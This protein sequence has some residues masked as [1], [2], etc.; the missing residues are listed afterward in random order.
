M[1]IGGVLV[2]RDDGVLAAAARRHARHDR[3]NYVV[4]LDRRQVGL[5]RLAP[6]VDRT[7]AG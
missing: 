4:V 2:A 5:Q 6:F 3:G 1:G 7:A